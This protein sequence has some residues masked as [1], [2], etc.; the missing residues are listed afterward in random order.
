MPYSLFADIVVLL[1]LTFVIFAVLGAVLIIWW[2]WVLWLHL[3]AV[4]WAGW[5]EMSGGICPLTPLENWLRW[6]A[7]RGGYQG[8]FVENYMLPVLYPTGLTRNMQI[9]LGTLV[10]FINV[11]IYG[12]IF[13]NINKRDQNRRSNNE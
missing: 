6:K 5:I 9:L 8:D 4:L 3:P 7:G 12:Y 13:F 1:H 2:R 10:I 11:A